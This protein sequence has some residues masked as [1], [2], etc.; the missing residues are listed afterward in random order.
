MGNQAY[1]LN[2]LC[3]YISS[4]SE[5]LIALYCESLKSFVLRKGYR[6]QSVCEIGLYTTVYTKIIAIDFLLRA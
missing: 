1:A 4:L 3:C 5:C 2:I 6:S